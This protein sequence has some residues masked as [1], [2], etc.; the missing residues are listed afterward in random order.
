M[1]SVNFPARA[2]VSPYFEEPD[3]V[4]TYAQASG[5]MELFEGG[6][7]RVKI[8]ADDLYVYVNTL[9]IRTNAQAS[10]V[11]PSFLPGP[12]LVGGQVSTQTYTLQ[13][14]V[15]Y[16]QTDL[17][18]ATRYA[19]GLPTALDFANR[20]GIYQAMRTMALYGVVPAN[21]EGLVNTAG[22]TAVN[23]PPDSLGNTTTVTYD[24]GQM[25]I[26]FLSQIQALLTNTYQTAPN[27]KQR[28]V[29]LS[30]QRVFLQFQL[31]NIVQLTSYQ[32]AGA[33]SNTT[34]GVVADV[35]GLS[36]VEVL[37]FYDDSLIGK[38]ASDADLVILTTPE[39]NIPAIA[40][41]NTDE[42]GNVKPHLKAVNLMY[43]D[44]AA[45][46][47]IPTPIPDGAI[48]EVHKIRVTC[49]WCVRPAALFLLSLPY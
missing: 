19:L 4:I 46:M 20:Q 15:E 21:N 5:F 24:N 47:K 43:T 48:E 28:V 14:R 10:Q 29:I 36:G 3:L 18:S 26:W 31:T 7:P 39:I 38:G 11:S 32:R 35:A 41:I 37:W 1:A 27:T 25:A 22:A 34:A 9:D 6:A 17:A 33:G 13:S 16:D 30:P 40:G 45:P 42:F 2:R 23:L 12:E 49:G 44:M 8:A